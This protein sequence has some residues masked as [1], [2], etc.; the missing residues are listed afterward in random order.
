MVKSVKH[1]SA[2]SV[3]QF[4]PDS[5]CTFFQSCYA[6]SVRV[7]GHISGRQVWFE[8]KFNTKL[9]ASA[10]LEPP[11]GPKV[12]TQVGESCI[13]DLAEKCMRV[14]GRVSKSFGVGACS[15]RLSRRRC[16]I[17][18]KRC[19]CSR[20]S[21]FWRCVGSAC[22]VFA[23]PLSPFLSFASPVVRLREAGRGDNTANLLEKVFAPRSAFRR[24]LVC[25]FTNFRRASRSRA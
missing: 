11:F 18:P 9:M 6:L 7:A 22:A 5:V 19:L 14:L 15:D 10:N 16:P 1:F 24:F 12:Q 2:R 21:A 17:P 3:M 20:I 4:S 13:T 8:L 25:I 23:I